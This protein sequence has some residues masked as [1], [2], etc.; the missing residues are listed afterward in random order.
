MP[1]S[2]QL[3]IYGTGYFDLFLKKIEGGS[4]QSMRTFVLHGLI[5]YGSEGLLSMMFCTHIVYSGT[6]DPREPIL[7]VSEGFLSKL[8]YTHIGC[9]ETFVLHEL[10]LCAQEDLILL[11]PCIHNVNIRIPGTLQY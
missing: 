9:M 7:C 11:L 2:H 10:I 8:L 4:G 5:F 1:T 6:A 3:S